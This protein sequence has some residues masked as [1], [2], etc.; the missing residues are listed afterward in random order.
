MNKVENGIGFI[1]LVL[2]LV[3]G[4]VFFERNV[5]FPLGN[6]NGNRLCFD[7]RFF[8]FCR[9]R[10]PRVPHGL[11]EIDADADAD[12]YDFGDFDGVVPHLYG[13]ERV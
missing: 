2:S 9:K 4:S 11:D 10:Q 12:V 1:V 5:F 3:L 7:A 6:R 13:C 8:R